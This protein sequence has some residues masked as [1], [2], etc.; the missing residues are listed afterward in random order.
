MQEAVAPTGVDGAGRRLTGGGVNDQGYLSDDDE[1]ED[2]PG[3]VRHLFTAI[4]AER[5][6]GIK[7][8][9]VRQWAKR[10]KIH[11]YGIDARGRPCYDR[12]HLRRCE[13]SGWRG[14][15][16]SSSRRT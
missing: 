14:S 3:R 10:G 6:L 5:V 12:D 8:G 11:S 1:S 13:Q 16:I 15:A 7:A 4:E 9:T 2:V